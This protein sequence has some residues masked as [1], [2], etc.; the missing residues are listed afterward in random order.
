MPDKIADKKKQIIKTS[1]HLFAQKGAHATSMQ[2]IAELCGISKG[3]L[4]QYFK[5]KEELE[6]SIFQYTFQSLYEEMVQVE[7]DSHLSLKEIFVKQVEVLLNHAMELHEFFMV[8]FQKHI[9]APEEHP[10]QQQYMMQLNL[11]S[12]RWL[13]RKLEAMYGPDIVPY[14]ADILL[15]IKGVLSSYVPLLIGRLKVALDFPKW[16]E[17]LWDIMDMYAASLLRKRPEPILPL[18]ALPEWSNGEVETGHEHRHPFVIIRELREAL[19]LSAMNDQD[20]EDAQESLRILESELME[21]KPRRA[22]VSGMLSNLREIE[23][24]ADMVD[25]LNQSIHKQ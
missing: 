3:T 21:L 23:E 9:G 17:N 25:E 12:L 19:K 15:L 4:Y 11:E 16:S 1:M 2:E 7:K 24:H 20:R 14:S 18:D 13:R 6:Q 8:Q 22:I 5:S 10:W